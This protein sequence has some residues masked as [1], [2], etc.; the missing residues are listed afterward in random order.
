[1]RLPRVMPK[2]CLSIVLGVTIVPSVW[3]GGTN[4]DRLT[5]LRLYESGQYQAAIPYFDN[6]LARH[7]RDLQIL[8]KRGSCYLRLN[9]PLKALDDFDRVTQHSIWASQVFAPSPILDTYNVWSS[10]PM[11]EFMF[12]ESWGHRGVA[13]LMLGRDEEALESFRTSV[14]LWSR[15]GNQPWTVLPQNQG[16][17]IRSKAGSY[18]G[19]GQAYLRLG[20]AEQAF[21][22]YGQAVAID[23]TDPN[24]FAGRAEV[25]AQLK[26]LDA[27]DLDYSEAIRLDPTHSRA[28]CGR[29][30]VRS[31]ARS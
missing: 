5:G 12:P 24:A 26:L 22:M 16:R 17:L 25:L 27:A 19:F 28:F 30:I 11:P 8:L 29:G 9:E 18:E 23:P 15:A 13:L 4:D 2:I 1:M 3:A 20:Q 31:G 14:N 10:V 7:T 6:V 21:Q